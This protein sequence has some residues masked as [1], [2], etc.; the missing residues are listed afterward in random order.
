MLRRDNIF[1]TLVVRWIK[2]PL[3]LN[4]LVKLPGLLFITSAEKVDLA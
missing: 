1:N 4:A 2:K 3:K